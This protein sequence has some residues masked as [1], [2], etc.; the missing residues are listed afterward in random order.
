MAGKR[1]EKLYSKKEV[2]NVQDKAFAAG[3]SDGAFYGERSALKELDG[4]V[5][6]KTVWRVL[7]GVFLILWACGVA[8]EMSVYDT[9]G[10]MVATFF[11]VSGVLIAGFFALL[12]GFFND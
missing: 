2:E 12:W 5:K 1:K 4:Y 10:S 6:K 8:Y 7:L 11:M 9:T 3:Y